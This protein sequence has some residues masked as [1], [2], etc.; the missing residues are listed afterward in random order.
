[1]TWRNPL[2]NN[3]DAKIEGYRISKESGARGFEDISDITLVEQ[4]EFKVIFWGRVSFGNFFFV[5]HVFLEFFYKAC[6]A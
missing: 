4:G 3:A 5:S 2:K 1:M 6:H